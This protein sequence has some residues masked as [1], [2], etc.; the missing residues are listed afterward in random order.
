MKFFDPE[1]FMKPNQTN[2]SEETLIPLKFA[3]QRANDILS[4]RLDFG[5]IRY[6]L[7]LVSRRHDIDLDVK[8]RAANELK[9]IENL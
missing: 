3:A 9:K 4:K 8:I 2:Q 5:A 7:Q 1:E 6:A